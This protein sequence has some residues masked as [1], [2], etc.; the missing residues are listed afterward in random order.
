M[1]ELQPGMAWCDLPS[2]VC[3]EAPAGAE[4]ER[5]LAP[6]PPAGALAELIAAA[7]PD[8][9]A[10]VP[11]WIAALAAPEVSITTVD[12]VRMLD[13]ADI[14]GLPVPPLVKGVFREVLKQ[15]VARSR[16]RAAVLQAT[17]ARREAFLA[18]LRDRNMQPPIAGSRYFQDLKSYRLILTHEE[19][20][21]GVRIVARRIENWCK[22]ERIVLVGILKGVF[23]FMS[24]LC[25]ALTRPH[26]VYFVE[27]SSYK[28]A[29][30]QAAS[31]AISSEMA[32]AKFFDAT[33]RAPHKVVL[34]DELLDNGETMHQMKLHLL[35]KLAATHSEKDILTVCAFSKQRERSA[36]EADITGIPNLPDLWLVGY[37]LDDRGTK[38]GWTE[39]FAI[40][41][42]KIVETIEQAEVEALLDRLDD[43]AVMTESLVFSG[44]ELTH[45]AKK[46]RY[47]VA[48]LDVERTGGHL[49]PARPVQT[50]ITKASLLKT[51]EGVSKVK[52]KFEHTL[53]F[54]FIQENV[55]LVPEDEIFSGN[56][57]VYVD[58][59]CRLR[60]NIITA[61]GRFAV[62]GPGDVARM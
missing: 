27:A 59:R 61:A 50:T 42:V 5:A 18:P 33:T 23:M 14:T 57:E 10:L 3:K 31:V 51:L 52:G 6:A 2:G 54:S 25:R 12:D 15:E 48:G 38:R 44:F 36:P 17:L 24:D 30:E 16:E 29:R 4:G 62:E 46:K 55:A 21:A 7:L 43:D 49:S 37:G 45:S 28:N 34:V 9:R 32:D 8:K 53:R 20:E 60:T 11:R 39:L 19:I 22:G 40:P 56:N 58:M 41:K 35:A 26:S 47:R 13:A 1:P